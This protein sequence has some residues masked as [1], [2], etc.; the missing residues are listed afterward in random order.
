MS[1]SDDDHSAAGGQARV[2][3]RLAKREVPR[4]PRNDQPAGSLRQGGLMVIRRQR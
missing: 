2:L 4:R 1:R 3:D